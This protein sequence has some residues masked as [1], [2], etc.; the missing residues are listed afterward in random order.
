[1]AFVLIGCNTA[2][3]NPG[4]IVVI[5][6]T[7]DV[8]IG[9]LV[10]D[11]IKQTSV[12]YP[13]GNVLPLLKEND[14]NIIN[15]ET[16]L[17]RHKEKVQKVFNFRSEP[18]H[19]E[20]LALGNIHVVTL[21]NNH[22]LDFFDKGL[23]ETIKVLDDKNIKHVGAGMN[24]NEARKPVVVK[25]KN[26]TIGVL[27]YT[28][29]EPSWRAGK[30]KPGI[31]FIEVGDVETVKQDIAAIRDKVDILVVTLHWGP[32][33]RQRP[34]R[35]FVD[36]AHALIDSGVDI[37][38]GH[39]AHIFQGIEIYKNKIIMYDTG[40]FVDDY[41]VTPELRNDT[42]FLFR[43]Y[44]TK[45]KFEKVELTPVLISNMQVNI[46]PSGLA[47][48]MLNKMKALS[49]EFNTKVAIKGEIGE[50]YVG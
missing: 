41:M 50:L 30:N 35:E 26:I 48:Q 32:N 11:V 4:E 5:G 21:A 42:S 47:K 39:S 37:I 46:A 29:N 38:H 7:G 44:A 25:R 9:R 6:F 49:A 24:E 15:L 14:L 19:V 13:W 16:T 1:L 3:K 31:S 43:V 28:D 2:N 45:E 33:M 10:N 34:T 27:G 22:S 20:T 23:F 36:F 12:N 18:E 17:T 8:M 40:D